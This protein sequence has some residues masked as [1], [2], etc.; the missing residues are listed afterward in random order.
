VAIVMRTRN[1]PLLLKRAITSV[2]AQSFRDW[3]L[4]VVNDG[5]DAA[6]VEALLRTHAGDLAGRATVL[7]HAAALGMEA[8]HNAGI[9]AT[10]S[11]FVAIHD[12]D[13]RWHADFLAK[14][15]GFLDAQRQVPGLDGVAVRILTISER[16]EG[17]SITE[18]GRG[19]FNLWLSRVTLFELCG[20]NPLLPIGL[21]YRRRVLDTIG[22]FRTDLKVLCDWEFYL[23]FLR[24]SDLHVLQ[25][26]LAYYHVR[27][28]TSG[29]YANSVLTSSEDLSLHEA[30][31]RNQLL[32]ED[33][34]AGRL[35]LGV[36][37]NLAVPINRVVENTRGQALALERLMKLPLVRGLARRLGLVKGLPPG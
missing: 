32:R 2:C 1:R 6:A 31:L 33:L 4:V 5:G 24:H 10:R 25:E 34:D 9:N 21:L 35:G 7:H 22:L 11:E 36:L 27:P 28:E 8:A 20:S 18:T 13:D 29:P 15:V 37:V 3:R 19:W 12:D 26:G 16:I 30:R 23:R 14:T 17:D